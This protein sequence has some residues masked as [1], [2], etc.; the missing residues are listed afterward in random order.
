VRPG[1]SRGSAAFD[2][3]CRTSVVTCACPCRS[4]ENG[5]RSVLGGPAIEIGPSGR[6]LPVRAVV[7]HERKARSTSDALP[8]HP[9]GRSLRNEPNAV[10]PSPRQ[11]RTPR[12]TFRAPS[13]VEWRRAPGLRREPDSRCRSRGFAASIRPPTLFRR[14]FPKGR[15]LD[16][17]YR[18]LITRGRSRRASL[19][20]FCNPCDP[21]A[22]SARSVETL[23]PLPE[24]EVP[25]GGS[26][27]ARALR[28]D[29]SRASAVRGSG[30]AGPKPGFS[31]LPAR[32]LACGRATPDR[33]TRTPLS[34]DPGSSRRG[35]VAGASN[36]PH[37]HALPRVVPG[38]PGG[39][40]HVGLREE[41]LRSDAPEVPSA[42]GPPRGRMGRPLLSNSIAGVERGIG[43]ALVQSPPDIRCMDDATGWVGTRP[44]GEQALS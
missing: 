37:A 21:R 39:A 31:L 13:I 8:A 4:A 25:C 27:G 18:G 35:A 34:R 36:L 26:A 14:R 7:D 6:L 32:L 29:R 43:Q 15:W 33:V 44:M 12:S 10:R 16:G 28:R 23:I 24:T 42:A 19:D 30:K 11:G 3:A 1:R 17:R 38:C 22:R 20:D 9:T 5:C 40:L 41:N 2:D